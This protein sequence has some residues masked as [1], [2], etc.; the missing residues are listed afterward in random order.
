MITKRLVN[1]N[2]PFFLVRLK[3]IGFI[4]IIVILFFVGMLYGSLL[5]GLGQA[6]TQEHLAFLT[7]QFLNKRVDQSIIYTFISSFN[8]SAIMLLCLFLCGFCAVGQ[9][10]ALFLPIFHG[11]GIGVSMSYLYYSQG[12]KGMLFSIALILPSA[13]PSTISLVLGTRESVRFSNTI[14]R[15]LFP[16]KYETPKNNGVKLYLLR[17][18]TLVIFNIVSAMIDS[19]CTFLFAGFFL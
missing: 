15:S 3:K 8:S 5:V 7:E 10:I 14:F 18:V 9:P 16:E 13:I 4:K 11:L 19:V 17:F 2:N 1:G 12:L 6:Q